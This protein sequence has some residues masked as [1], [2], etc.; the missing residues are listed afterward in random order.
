[1]VQLQDFLL[2]DV[3]HIS[4]RETNKHF[5]SRSRWIKQFNCESSDCSSLFQMS[6]SVNVERKLSSKFSRQ[7][8]SQVVK[9]V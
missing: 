4:F 5:V 1:M 7:V 9:Q 2:L 3:G 8:L 6:L